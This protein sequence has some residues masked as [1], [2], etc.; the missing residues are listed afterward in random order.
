M[1][2][3]SQSQKKDKANRPRDK[4]R[5]VLLES[6]TMRFVYLRTRKDVIWIGQ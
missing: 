6:C 5:I 3:N 2:S 4:H 1:L